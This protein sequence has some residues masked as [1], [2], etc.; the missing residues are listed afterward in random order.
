M[1]ELEQDIARL[2]R[3]ENVIDHQIQILEE[4]T[5]EWLNDNP[6]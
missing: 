1:D 5:K 2:R 3:E 4:Q 6:G